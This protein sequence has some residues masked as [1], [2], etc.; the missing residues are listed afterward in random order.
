[1]G[2]KDNLHLSDNCL[3]GTMCTILLYCHCLAGSVGYIGCLILF[4]SFHAFMVNNKGYSH[5]WE[6][7]SKDNLHLSDNCLKGTMCTILLYC[8]CLA[9]SVG[10]MGCL[11]LFQSCRIPTAIQKHNSMIFPWFFMINKCNFYDYLMHCLQTP[12][13]AASSPH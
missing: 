12:L 4:K 6:M 3:K 5:C 11:I 1:M 7:G 13:L 10:Y 2:S 8:H 9:G